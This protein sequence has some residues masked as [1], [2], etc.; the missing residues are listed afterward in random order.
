MSDR[1][2]HPWDIAYNMVFQLVLMAPTHLKL[3]A[4]FP[5]PFRIGKWV[6]LQ[7]EVAADKVLG[8]ITDQSLPNL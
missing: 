4:I 6:E 3:C 1:Y 7:K 8:P 2:I 5:Q